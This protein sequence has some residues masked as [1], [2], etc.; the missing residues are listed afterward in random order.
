MAM[1]FVKGT[2]VSMIKRG[3]LD[4]QK[5]RW[6]FASEE[7]FASFLSASMRYYEKILDFTLSHR[8]IVRILVFESLKNGK[9][10]NALFRVQELIYNKEKN[11]LFMTIWNADQDF[12][13]STDSIVFKFFFGFV[14]MFNFAAYFDDYITASKISEKE[15]RASFLNAYRKLLFAFV[16]GKDIIL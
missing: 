1:D 8:R 6:C 3:Q 14:P 7:D 13:Y 9:H 15:L 12:E 11:S 5:K 16:D 10:H 4:I 2:I